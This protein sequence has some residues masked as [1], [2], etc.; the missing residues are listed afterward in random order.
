M[1]QIVKIVFGQLVYLTQVAFRKDWTLHVV[2]D[3]VRY[4]PRRSA[5]PAR[6]SDREQRAI[7]AA[8]VD[9]GS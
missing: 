1:F 4:V 2:R 9:F 3:D 6:N 7:S 5:L 8:N